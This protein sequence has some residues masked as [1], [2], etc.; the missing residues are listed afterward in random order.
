MNSGPDMNSVKRSKQTHL[1]QMV[2]G[3]CVLCDLTH[4]HKHSKLLCKTKRGINRA[5]KV[6]KK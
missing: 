5:R 1:I 3:S 4:S 6:F 2:T